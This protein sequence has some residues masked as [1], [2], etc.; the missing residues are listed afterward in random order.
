MIIKDLE[1]L[2]MMPKPLNKFSQVQ[3]GLIIEDPIVELTGLLNG[4]QDAVQAT[5]FPSTV[6]I[7]FLGNVQAGGSALFKTFQGIKIN[8]KSPPLGV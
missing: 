2:E 8:A 1:H 6:K 7:N 5:A 3:G 4:M